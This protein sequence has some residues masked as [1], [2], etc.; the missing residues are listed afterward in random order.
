VD[1]HPIVRRGLAELIGQ[2]AGL[3]VCG[4]AADIPEAM[5]QIRSKRPDLAV[6][7]ISLKSG[8]GIELIK[9]INHHDPRIRVLVSSVY[10]ES[11]YAERALRAGAMGYINK[12]EALDHIIG[13]IRQVLSG[14]VFLS[15]DMT[16]RLLHQSVT[17]AK[18]EKSAVEA[19]SSRELEVFELIGRGFT[20]SQIAAKLHRSVKTI[21]A[22]R[23][24]LKNKLSLATGAQLT[25]YAVQWVLENR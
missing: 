20:S 22:H 16:T 18:Q 2:S 17:R 15:A 19:L 6:V 10:D 25:C 7:D 14:Q 9:Q 3:T 23:E 11:L 13:A 24:N 5:E 1:D 8:S 12:E 21:E 4:E